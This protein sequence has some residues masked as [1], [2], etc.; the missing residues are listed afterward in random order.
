MW[1]LP[2]R[3]TNYLV[4]HQALARVGGSAGERTLDRRVSGVSLGERQGKRLDQ[5]VLG[6]HLDA[7]RAL[8]GCAVRKLS[9]RRAHA[10]HRADY[11]QPPARVDRGCRWRRQRLRRVSH[12]RAFAIRRGVGVIPARHR[13]NC[14]EHASRVHRLSH[15]AG[16]ARGDGG[17]HELRREDVDDAAAHRLRRVSRSARRHTDPS[18]AVR[19]RRTRPRSQFVHALPSAAQQSGSHVR[20][21]PALA[22]G[23]DAPRHRRVVS[24]HPDRAGHHRDQRDA[25][26]ADREPL[27]LRDVSRQSSDGHGQAHGR[28][29]LPEHGT[30][31]PC[32][33]VPR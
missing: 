11:R 25:R 14:P 26:V 27:A 8:P 18:T 33:P 24:A 28:V 5:C 17:E 30:Q 22:T 2:R 31:L 19:D 10:H 13:R 1:Q 6:L 32:D 20:Q 23:P 21:R 12:R 4:R 3:S 29:H 9:R 7:G 16:R 15:G